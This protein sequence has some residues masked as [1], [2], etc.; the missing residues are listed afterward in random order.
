MIVSNEDFKTLIKNTIALL[1]CWLIILMPVEFASAFQMTSGPTVEDISSNSAKIKFTTDVPTKAIVKYGKTVPQTNTQEYPLSTTHLIVLTGLDPLT[2][3]LYEVLLNNGS[4]TLRYNNSNQYYQFTTQ[5]VAD[6]T[7][8]HA[9]LNLTLVQAGKTTAAFSW[10]YDPLDTD[11]NKVNVYKDNVQ[12]ESMYA[13]TSYT[14]QGLQ[15]GTT[16]TFKFAAID[17]AGNE[18]PSQELQATTL[19]EHFEIIEIVNVR[20]EV[21]GTQA[22]IRWETTTLTGTS[23]KYGT[24]NTSLT[25]TESVAG[26]NTTSHNVTLARLQANTTYYYRVRSCDIHENCGE[27]EVFNFTTGETLSLFLEVKGFDDNPATQFYWNSNLLVIE[28]ETAPFAEIDVYV[29]NNRAR[30]ARVKDTGKFDFRAIGLDPNVQQNTVKVAVTDKVTTIEK[31]ETVVIDY[32]APEVEFGNVSSFSEDARVTIT[33][34]ITETYF[35]IKLDISVFSTDTEAPKAPEGLFVETSQNTATL[36]WQDVNATDFHAYL[37]YRSKAPGEEPVLIAT[38]QTETYTDARLSSGS[39][40]TYRVTAMDKSGNE[41]TASEIVAV[42]ETGTFTAEPIDEIDRPEPTKVLSKSLSTS[43]LSE[44][45]Q[46][47]FEGQTNI[48]K[49][50]FTDQAGNVYTKEFDIVFDTAAPRF[51]EP[52]SLDYYSPASTYVINIKGKVD[53]NAT[54]EAY[55]DGDLEDTVRTDDDGSFSV[56]ISFPIISAPVISQ[57]EGRS[58]GTEQNEA[59]ITALGTHLV[60]LYAIDEAGHKSDPLSGNIVHQSCGAGNWWAVEP[61]STYPSF[62]SPMRMI[63][64]FGTYNIVLGFKW[65]GPGFAEEARINDVRLENPPLSLDEQKKYDNFPPNSW[66]SGA[67]QRFPVDPGNKTK[68]VLTLNLRPPASV[69]AGT[70]QVEI[71]KNI[72]QYRKGEC[73]VPGIGCLKFYYVLVIDF[74]SQA[75]VNQYQQLQTGTSEQVAA[76]TQQRQCLSNYYVVFDREEATADLEIDF[77]LEFMVKWL[78][79]TVN[80]VDAIYDPILKVTEYT[81]YG[82]LI[83]QGVALLF[84]NIW[85]E[86]SCK[87]GG[88]GDLKDMLKTVIKRGKT[89]IESVAEQGLCEVYYTEDQEKGKQKQDKCKSCQGWIDAQKVALHWQDYVCDRLGCPSV[90]SLQKHIKDSYTQR[91]SFRTMRGGKSDPP[92]GFSEDDFKIKAAPLTIEQVKNMNLDAQQMKSVLQASSDCEYVFTSKDDITSLYE[93]YTAN[94]AQIEDVCSKPHIFQPQCCAY[95]YLYK[96]NPAALLIDPLELSMCLTN[97]T[98]EKC[99]T[100]SRLIKSTTGICEPDRPRTKIEILDRIQ[101]RRNMLQG[102]QPSVCATPQVIY[103]LEYNADGQLETMRRGCA[104]QRVVVDQSI[105][106]GT[107]SQ[108]QLIPI[109]TTTAFYD[110]GNPDLLNEF[111]ENAQ[112]L[113]DL[114]QNPEQNK[115]EIESTKEKMKTSFKNELKSSPLIGET[116][117]LLD[118]AYE[119]VMGTVGVEK[120]YVLEPGQSLFHAIFTVCLTKVLGWLGTIRA[121]AYSW[122]VCFQKILESGDGTAGACQEFVAIGICDMLWEI[123]SCFAEKFSGESSRGTTSGIEGIF[124]S[125]SSAGSASTQHLADRYGQQSFLTSQLSLNRLLHDS[126]IYAFTGEW[127]SDW[128]NDLQTTLVGDTAPTGMVFGAERFFQSI[129]QNGQAVYVYDITSQLYA[130]ADVPTYYLKLTCSGIEAKCPGVN[131]H[132]PVLQGRCDCSHGGTHPDAQKELIVPMTVNPGTPCAQPLTKGSMCSAHNLQSISSPV[133]YDR[134]SVVYKYRNEKGEIIEGESNVKQISETTPPSVDM[135]S[136]SLNSLSFSCSMGVGQENFASILDIKPTRAS[137]EYG[138]GDSE[139][140]E[141]TVR[142]AVPTRDADSSYTSGDTMDQKFLFITVKNNLGATG[143]EIYPLFSQYG[144]IAQPLDTP[145]TYTLRFF[146]EYDMPALSGSKFKIEEKHFLPQVSR[147]SCKQVDPSKWSKRITFDNP[148]CDLFKTEVAYQIW[149]DGTDYYYMKIN[150]QGSGASISPIESNL[151]ID[152]VKVQGTKC[153]LIGSTIDCPVADLKPILSASHTS[154]PKDQRAN[155]SMIIINSPSLLGE[156]AS[157]QQL[158]QYCKNEP[159]KWTLIAEIRDATTNGAVIQPSASTAIDPVTGQPARKEM[160]FFVRCKGAPQ[161]DNIQN[162]GTA[163]RL[164]Y[165]TPTSPDF[166]LSVAG[167][168]TGEYVEIRSFAARP[169]GFQIDIN[170]NSQQPIFLEMNLVKFGYAVTS[171]FGINQSMQIGPLAL[172]TCGVADCFNLTENK[173][174]LNLRKGT[175]RYIFHGLGKSDSVEYIGESTPATPSAKECSEGKDCPFMQLCVK[176][177]D[178]SKGSC[179]PWYCNNIY[180]CR[181][182]AVCDIQSERCVSK[183]YAEHDEGVCFNTATGTCEE[184]YEQSGLCPDWGDIKTKCCTSFSMLNNS[185]SRLVET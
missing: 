131:T 67:P 134:V 27:S 28:G 59:E 20:H 4:Q 52:S 111:V 161:I 164:S 79:A 74:Y 139:I 35:P 96:W 98:H 146:N 100:T 78:N 170:V 48:V 71:M 16:Y 132:D 83:A 179:Q 155:S 118:K 12:I 168:A 135:C 82:C 36:A 151:T 138:V 171:S 10:T 183:C 97:P 58:P 46:L 115:A 51:L 3:Y 128:M 65:Q 37:I 117:E 152:Q 55:V 159:V 123:I 76:P 129:G 69:G 64:G 87:F 72:S 167:L 13:G 172:K 126:C 32:Y 60:E 101:Y 136:F 104:A 182:N 2:L 70:N 173:V 77:I 106:T 110:L 85:K 103:Y 156:P 181:S 162:L 145:G 166:G 14:A 19:A 148:R 34:S 7:P 184:G 149:D 47:L 15:P 21:F 158:D 91:T 63:N 177:G 113:E 112:K 178:A 180:Q 84:I 1:M 174:T 157:G 143:Q 38:S 66:V 122:M 80:A 44:S 185:S 125:I 45:I 160:E 81:L 107:I 75:L 29:N 94:E 40:Y 57:Q 50:D 154:K 42:T 175:A 6:T 33:G 17:E 23:V 130:G 26:D 95:D 90:P 109:S 137:K 147:A 140:A 144:S 114:Q 89:D 93:Q 127:P 9:L 176:E 153:A 169:D 5:Q 49:L 92:T 30:H 61:L 73:I 163:I 105:E 120:E 43:T 124:A 121:F 54:I 25:Q 116:D 86:Y 53:D 24:S 41:G 22:E 56:E 11:T 165:E 108:D 8:P 31:T 150:T 99:G 102:N 39:E 133:R 68:W 18:G 119:E 62:I 88:F 142:R 141:I